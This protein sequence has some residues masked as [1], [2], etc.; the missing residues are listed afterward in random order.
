MEAR[1]GSFGCGA[2]PLCRLCSPTR[3]LSVGAKGGWQYQ[4]ALHLLRAARR[5]ASGLN[6]FS[7]DA[8]FSAWEKG[9]QLGRVPVSPYL[10]PSH[11]LLALHSKVGPVLAGGGPVTLRGKRSVAVRHHIFYHAWH[12]LPPAARKMHCQVAAHNRAAQARGQPFVVLF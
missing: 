5:Q 8:V 3:A 1:S 6:A 7:Y 9:Q 11:P 10:M 2:L 12:G 4:Q